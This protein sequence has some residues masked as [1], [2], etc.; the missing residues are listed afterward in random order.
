MR[1]N[2]VWCGSL[3]AMAV[4]IAGCNEGRY[5]ESPGGKIGPSSASSLVGEVRI[6]GSS[7]VYPMGEATAAEFA[8]EFP[9]VKVAIGKSGTGGGF[10]RFSKGET[11]ISHASRPIK[12]AEFEQCQA[13]QVQFLELPVAIDGLTVVVHPENDF[14]DQ[15][16]VDQLRTIFRDDLAAKTWQ[17]VHPDWPAET[18][19]IYAPGTDSGTFDYF[20]EVIVGKDEQAAMRADMSVSEDDNVLVTGVSGEKYS[21]GFFGAAYYFENEDKLRAVPIVN[22]DTDEAVS[23]TPERIENGDYAPL[24]RPLFIY[25]NAKSLR[26]P[27]IK[28]YVGFFVDQAPRISREVGYVSLPSAI[29]ERSA[30]HLAERVLGTHFWQPSGESRSGPMTEMYVQEHALETL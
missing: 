14:V 6:D 19:K 28:K 17:E 25:V 10:K 5:V 11:D 9:Q 13:N 20:K 8:E 16:S 3:T 4:L 15:L 22:P 18:I 24:S 29:Q 26:R 27:E 30:Q 23:P 2:I 21:V 12:W 1:R 7:T